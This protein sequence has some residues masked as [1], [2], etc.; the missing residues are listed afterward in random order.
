MHQFTLKR[1]QVCLN[2]PNQEIQGISM[3]ILQNYLYVDAQSILKDTLFSV[4]AVEILLKN[5]TQDSNHELKLTSL[6]C[7]SILAVNKNI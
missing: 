2:S 3:L 4:A 6:K 1:L 7:M 5:I